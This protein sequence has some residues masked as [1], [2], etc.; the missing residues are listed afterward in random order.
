MGNGCVHFFIID[1]SLLI[2]LE[3]FRGLFFFKLVKCLNLRGKIEKGP[4]E[5]I[6]LFV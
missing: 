2:S 3:I 6:S 5:R 4:K 1:G